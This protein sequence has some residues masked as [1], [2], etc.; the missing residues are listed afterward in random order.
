[1]PASDGPQ[2]STAS[3]GPANIQTPMGASNQVQRAVNACTASSTARKPAVTSN[4][5]APSASQ[6]SGERLRLHPAASAIQPAKAGAQSASTRPEARP[7]K[8]SARRVVAACW[9]A[10]GVA[11]SSAASRQALRQHTAQAQVKS[12]K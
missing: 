8:T 1:M 10:L 7:S 12:P 9:P 4:N 11:P 6:R 5:G 3:A 2:S